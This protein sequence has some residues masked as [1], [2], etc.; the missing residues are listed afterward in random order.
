M[1]EQKITGTGS[2][3]HLI[4]PLGRIWAFVVY[5][6]IYEAII[7]GVFG[8]AVF[9]QGRSGWWILAA[10]VVSGAQLK[11]SRFGIAP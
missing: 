5:T 8:W 7:W 4:E 1:E 10:A 6:V 11:P 3:S 2:Q 9:V